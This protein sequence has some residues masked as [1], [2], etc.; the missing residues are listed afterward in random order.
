[1][2]G[3]IFKQERIPPAVLNGISDTAPCKEKCFIANVAILVQERK[4]EESNEIVS[5]D[6]TIL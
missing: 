2:K 3:V 1:M 4:A 6:Q 5:I